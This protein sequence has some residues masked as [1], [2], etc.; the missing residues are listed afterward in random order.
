M[1]VAPQIQNGILRPATMKF[2]AESAFLDASAPMTTIITKY[3]PTPMKMIVSTL[4][5]LIDP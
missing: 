1:I 4:K 5:R 2:A 3:T